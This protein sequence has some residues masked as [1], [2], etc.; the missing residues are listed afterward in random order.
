[1][2]LAPSKVSDIIVCNALLVVTNYP[3]PSSIFERGVEGLI[4]AI[5][6]LR[7]DRAEPTFRNVAL[8]PPYPGSKLVIH[9]TM[10]DKT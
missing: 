6:S 8:A 7:L 3:Q 4:Q 10:L 2:Y 1:M 9:H 5:F